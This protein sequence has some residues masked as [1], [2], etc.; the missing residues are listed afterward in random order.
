VVGLVVVALATI[1]LSMPA[2]GAADDPVVT[3]RPATDLVDGSV[4]HVTVTGALP[5]AE[6]FANVC[7]ADHEIEAECFGSV[8]RVFSLDPT[9]AGELDLGLEAVFPDNGLPGNPETDCRVAPGCVLRVTT[10]RTDG[11]IFSAEA[12][13]GFRPDGPLLPPP[14]ITVEPAADLVDG[15]TVEVQGSGFVPFSGVALAQCVAP[16]TDSTTCEQPQEYV[17]AGADGSF[18]QT[19]DLAAI[20]FPDFGSGEADCRATDCVLHADRG[21]FQ[22]DPLRT[23]SAPLEFRADGPLLPPPTLTVAPS[24]GLVDGQ[25][26]QVF[27]SGF[28]RGTF[29]VAQCAAGEEPGWSRCASGQFVVV[30]DNGNLHASIAARVL[31]SRNGVGT[32]CREAPGCTFGVLDYGGS[33]RVVAE[34]SVAFDPNGPGPL[35]PTLQVAPS[36]P[37]PGRS[38]LLAMGAD[39]PP[40][41]DVYF[42][43]CAYADGN[44]TECGG[45]SGEYVQVD[46]GGHLLA[47]VLVRPVIEGPDGT[48]IDCRREPCALV[49]QS[50]DA[51][52]AVAPLSFRPPPDAKPRRYLDPVFEGVD[53]TTDILYRSTVNGRG[54]PVDLKLNVYRP[55][56]DTNTRRPAVMFMFGGY[57]GSGDRGQLV[58]LAQGMARRGYVAV[59]ID[60]RTR[61]WIFDGGNGCVPVGGTCLDPTQLGPAITDARDDGRAA[62]VWLHEHAAEYGIDSRAISAAGW[63]AGAITALNL[64]HDPTG[65]RPEAS[66][67]AAAVSLGGILTPVPGA[68]DAPTLMMGGSHD[69][70][71]AL[72]SQIAGCDVINEAGSHC[73]FV[74]YAGAQPAPASDPCVQLDVPCTYVLGRDG[75]HGWFFGDRPDTLGRISG[76]LAREVLVPNGILPGGPRPPSH[77]P[78]DHHHHHG[79]HHHHHHGHHDHG[80]DRGHDH[81]HH[82]HRHHGHPHRHGGASHR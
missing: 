60:Y 74:A 19:V 5:S 48:E 69:S 78:H 7:A 12:P 81:R 59:T 77:P 47:G 50:F 40:S 22:P 32:D 45:G 17:N 36:T 41:T 54:A 35:T 70:L 30:D 18:T 26:V 31:V 24:D 29:A 8:S 80:D 21:T 73:E 76:F 61:P 67:P 15:Q 64:V 75:E 37:L 6:L 43:Q 34:A 42:T 51:L 4:V 20:I 9:G 46:E 25:A 56:G 82:G 39:F 55:A 2:A 63:S 79:G 44:P 65:D 38:P 72:S 62:M 52:P 13:L 10:Q 33:S 28:R 11:S 57:F 49:A 23:A 66:I 71:L 16:G 1:G 53:A 27:G 68:D 58:E 3:V 14:T